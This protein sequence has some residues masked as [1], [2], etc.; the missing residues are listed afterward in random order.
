MKKVNIFITIIFTIFFMAGIA[1]LTQ[2]HHITGWSDYGGY[3]MGHGM[4]GFGGM[5]IMMP[6]FWG[7]VLLVFIML[8]RLLGNNQE[9]CNHPE[10]NI[11]AHEILKSRYAKGEI[12]KDELKSMMYDL[13]NIPP[14]T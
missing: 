9:R 10:D 5:G 11:N 14:G 4:M 2:S 13:N 3:H 1:F 12:D 7:L 8:I 6:V